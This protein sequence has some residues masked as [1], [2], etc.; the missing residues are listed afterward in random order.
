MVVKQ[1]HQAVYWKRVKFVAYRPYKTK[2][3]LE[4]PEDMVIRSQ[5]EPVARFM[6]EGRRQELV[7]LLME[8]LVS[9][10]YQDKDLYRQHR[11][12]YE[13]YVDKERK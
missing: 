3:I 1:N 13:K 6:L 11:E 12:L 9:K 4:P 8:S 10:Y 5:A 7:D 2:K